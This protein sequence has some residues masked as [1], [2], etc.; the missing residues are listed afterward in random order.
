[1]ISGGNGRVRRTASIVVLAAVGAVVLAGAAWSSQ[2]PT[3]GH[4]PAKSPRTGETFG[5]SLAYDGQAAASKVGFAR[6]H[7]VVYLDPAGEDAAAGDITRVVVS[8]EH[9]GKVTFRIRIANRP[10][11][12]GDLGIQIVLDADQN[13]RTGNGWLVRDLGA[14]YL[15][16]VYDGRARLQPWTSSGSRRAVAHEPGVHFSYGFSEATIALRASVLGHSAGFNFS[17][18]TG[19]GIV[20]QSDGSLDITYAR[21]DFAPDVGH[22]FWSFP[23]DPPTPAHSRLGS[24]VGR[25]Q[26]SSAQTR[27]FHRWRR[28][29]ALLPSRA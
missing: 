6:S 4:D 27:Q 17:V 25:M 14:E 29:E 10:V 21:F 11:M 20:P 13:A 22:G 16:G 18:S 8:R 1:V 5:F 9:S 24:G 23:G 3:A 28:G 26:S 7:S 15:I 12:S 2:A 19:A